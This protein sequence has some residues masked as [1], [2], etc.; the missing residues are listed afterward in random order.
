LFEK[1]TRE[2]KVEEIKD[3]KEKT[4]ILNEIIES[5][6]IRMKSINEKIVKLKADSKGLQVIF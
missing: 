1:Y 5:S 2:K 3:L 4:K 6:K